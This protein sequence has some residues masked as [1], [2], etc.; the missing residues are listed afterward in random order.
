MGGNWQL[1]CIRNKMFH[2]N[3]GNMVW[4][5]LRFTFSIGRPGV[6]VAVLPFRWRYSAWSLLCP[7]GRY[8]GISS[9]SPEL[10]KGWEWS[11]G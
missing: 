11:R 2:F 8:T 4:P 9:G 6:Y 10:G 5:W 3:E 1:F 7:S